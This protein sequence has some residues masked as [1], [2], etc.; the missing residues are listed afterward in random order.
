MVPR[1]S[2][3]TGEEQE[4]ELRPEEQKESTSE[5]CV[6]S[7]MDEARNKDC[8]SLPPSPT[9][10]NDV[11]GFDLF[12]IFYFIHVGAGMACSQRICLSSMLAFAFI[13]LMPPIKKFGRSGP[14]SAP[15]R[16][17]D[18]SRVTR[19]LVTYNHYY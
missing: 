7:A 15:K 14:P 12:F 13:S 16:E 6:Q 11:F 10:W 4:K 1:R 5:W 2:L 19:Q 17:E 9:I 3:Q 8:W 18:K